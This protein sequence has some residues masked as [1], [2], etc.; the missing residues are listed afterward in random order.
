MR[1]LKEEVTTES[2]T[3]ELSCCRGSYRVLVN[4]GSRGIAAFQ[5]PGLSEDFVN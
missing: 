2:K 4:L 1:G 3:R 5:Y